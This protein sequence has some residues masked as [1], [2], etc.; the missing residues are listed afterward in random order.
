MNGNG[1]G[2]APGYGRWT[3]VAVLA[4]TAATSGCKMGTAGT[5]P[6]WWTFGGA[7]KDDADKFAAAPSF[8]GDVTKPSASAKPYPTT[9]TP[10]AYAID[11]ATKPGAAAVAAAAPTAVT[12]G[13][14][15]PTAPPDPVEM[16]TAPARS[17]A[18]AGTVPPLTSIT[19]QVGPYASLPADPAAAAGVA[20]PPPLQAIAGGA[21]PAAAP[22]VGASS[23][24][25]PPAA[26]Q[27]VAD[28][29]G[30][31]AWPGQQ[32]GVS[33]GGRYDAGSSSRFGGGSAI[34]QPLPPPPAASVLP[35]ALEPLPAAATPAG[36]VPSGGFPAPPAAAPPAA[37]VSPTAP[38]RRADPAYRPG[39]TSSYRPSRAILAADPLPATPGAVRPAGF[40]VPAADLP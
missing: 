22:T 1:T 35:A 29:R 4:V 30:S 13:V 9:G 26:P 11:G 18:A 8:N 14:T 28:A 5:R 19:P 17:N 6:S 31:A 38:L 24:L 21:A 39:G 20:E 37:P 40:E 12:Y 2:R 10:N 16:A 34:D 27:R 23:S 3:V 32:A 25:A 7:P 36:A 15:P 33:T